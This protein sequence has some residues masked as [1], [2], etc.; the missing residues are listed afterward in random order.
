MASCGKRTSVMTDSEL[1]N[2]TSYIRHAHTPPDKAPAA[3][4]HAFCSV[5]VKLQIS[6]L[7]PYACV[8][9]GRYQVLRLLNLPYSLPLRSFIP[10][11]RCTHFDGFAFDLLVCG[12]NTDGT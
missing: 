8:N 2:L 10:L 12:S 1:T 3:C 4:I 9:A 11:H 7:S 6:L 5:S